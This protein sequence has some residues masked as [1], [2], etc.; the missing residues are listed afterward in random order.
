MS[1]D[2]DFNWN[3]GLANASLGKYKEAEELLLKVQ[4]ENYKGEYTYN[5]WL[6]KCYI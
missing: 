5:A 3:F 6:A 2:D 4:D 1:N